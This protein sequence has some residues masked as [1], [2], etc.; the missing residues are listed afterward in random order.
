MKWFI[1][2]LG[3]W[4]AFCIGLKV[5]DYVTPDCPEAPTQ[6]YYDGLKFGMEK[7]R[8]FD[9]FCLWGD[10]TPEQIDSA[11]TAMCGLFKQRLKK[12]GL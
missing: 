8:A 2:V 7:Q 3:L 5:E 9:A 10:P 6:T 11:A 4:L 1:I 12:A